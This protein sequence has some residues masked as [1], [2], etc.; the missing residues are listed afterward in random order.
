MPE[1]P[2]VAEAVQ[3]FLER[4]GYPVVICAPLPSLRQQL[5]TGQA[6]VLIALGGDG[7]ML[8]A[9]H[10]CA[11]LHIPVLGIN[12][13]RFGF[14]MEVRQ[15][16]WQRRLP[17][18]LSGHY[19]LEERMMLVATHLRGA[20]TLGEWS[21]LNEVVVCRGQIVR[22]VRL[23]AAVDGYPLSTYIADGLIVATPTGSTAYALAVG[24][25]IMP[26][27]LR[28]ILI[29]AVA[30]HLSMDRAVILPPEAVVTVTVQSSH[31]AVMS[32]DGQPPLPLEND[33]VVQVKANHNTVQFI[34]FQDRGYF[35]R[36]INAY[37]ELN[38]AAM[39]SER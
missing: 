13:G 29:V 30:P 22:P 1:A 32:V 4:Q 37:M 18:L 23:S 35:Y 9:G 16:E 39:D 38:P 3:R 10:L 36:N 8:R 21:V 11:P 19:W 5:Q 7:T 28:S 24:G 27:E 17:L 26:P 31:Q 6:D 2:L 34:R 15:D 33:D 25:P 12:L 14:L 20:Q